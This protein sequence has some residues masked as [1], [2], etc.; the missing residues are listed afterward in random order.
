MMA[1]LWGDWP[2]FSG[3]IDFPVP[4]ER[5]TP[6]YPAQRRAPYYAFREKNKWTGEYG[7]LRR[8]LLDFLIEKT[9]PHEIQNTTIPL[10]LI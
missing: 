7:E 8:E 2:N 4:W 3:N 1:T 9:T 6:E 10:P 5:A